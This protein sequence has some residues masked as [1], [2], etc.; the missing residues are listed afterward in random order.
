MSVAPSPRAINVI[1]PTPASSAAS[2]SSTPSDNVTA[3]EAADDDNKMFQYVAD[4]KIEKMSEWLRQHSDIF[5]HLS[6]GLINMPVFQRIRVWRVTM[7]M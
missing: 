5:T 4:D 7:A 3:A 1:P 6:A 2:V